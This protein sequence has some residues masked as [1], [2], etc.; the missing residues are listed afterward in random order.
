[1]F[2]DR[3]LVK[4]LGGGWGRWR[5]SEG[6]DLQGAYILARV[7]TER[8]WTVIMD[9]NPYFGAA[10]ERGDSGHKRRQGILWTE[11]N[12]LVGPR[13][14]TANQA[15]GFSRDVGGLEQ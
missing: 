14:M 3:W 13:I 5:V 8:L 7:Q 1:M 6:D 11:V 12:I 15:G 9:R 4:R 10:V 2:R